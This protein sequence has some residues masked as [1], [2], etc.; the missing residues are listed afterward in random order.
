[1]GTQSPFKLPWTE[2]YQTAVARGDIYNAQTFG[3]YGELTTIGSVTGQIIWPD[4]VYNLPPAA[5]VQMSLVSTSASDGV[6]GTGIRSVDI[7]YLDDLLAPQIETVVLNG[8]TPVLTVAT[9]MR[10]IQCMHMITFGTNKKAVG[11]ITASNGGTTY[12]LVAIGQVRCTSSVRMV[13]AGKRLFITGLCGG[14]SSGTAA[15]SAII[16]LTSTSF[17]GHD[18]STDSVFIPFASATAQDGSISLVLTTP[19]SFLEGTAVGMETTVDKA[20]TIV[21]SWFGWLEDA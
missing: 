1:M 4:G 19:V 9:N 18:Y 10:F 8:T 20:A 21:G 3:G 11:T 12:S 2:S 16:R 14:S 15:A 6:A 5:G 13:P 7:H 17:D